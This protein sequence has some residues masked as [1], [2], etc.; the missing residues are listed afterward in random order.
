MKKV[1]TGIAVLL[2]VAVSFLNAQTL[3]VGT[4]NIRY[5]NPEDSLNNWKYRKQFAID[6]IKF[7]EY[8]VF[9]IQEGLMNQVNDLS[10]GLTGYGHVGV[11]R[12]DGKTA[13]EFSAI[14][15]RKDR[16]QLLDNGTFWLSGTDINHPN[17]G[18]DAVL[19]RICTWAKF[20][21]KQTG[22][23]FF[24]FN[25]H[26]DH[27]GVTARKESAALILRMIDKIAGK[28]PVILTGDFNVDQ[29]S[30]SYAVINNSG[31][32][33]DS[34]QTAAFRFAYN[35]TFQGFNINTH[36]D[37][38]IDHVFL[39]SEFKALKY[40]VL[41]DNYPGPSS[42]VTGKADSGNFPKEVSLSKYEARLASDHFPV[43][44]K[45]SY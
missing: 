44:V 37:S 36:T 22:K 6:L 39:S 11:G 45:V 40:G 41:T 15:Y 12:D 33:K 30:D 16:L 3:N 23:V 24:H 28:A 35:G 20:K 27:V 31:R 13:G 38:R 4:F 21:D 19:P 17:K 9:G 32:F 2:L 43:F 42:S 26:F 10:A 18:W 5:D 7:H 8:D 1:T 29:N 34:Y 14:F 25:T